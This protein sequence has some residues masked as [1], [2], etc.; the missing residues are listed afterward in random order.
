MTNSPPPP[1]PIRRTA[2][3]FINA[4]SRTENHQ[5]DNHAELN[6][7]SVRNLQFSVDTSIGATTHTA[8]AAVAGSLCDNGDA[9]CKLNDNVNGGENL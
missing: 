7:L 5:N 8:M 2:K 4:D 6:Q 3:E 1:P 9:Q